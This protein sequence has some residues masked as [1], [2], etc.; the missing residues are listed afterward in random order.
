MQFSSVV[1]LLLSCCVWCPMNCSWYCVLA[2]CGLAT[3]Q[4]AKSGALRWIL[5]CLCLYLTPFLCIL[6][7]FHWVMGLSK[8]WGSISSFANG[9]GV[10]GFKNLVIPESQN[11]MIGKGDDLLNK[12]FKC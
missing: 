3:S 12:I 11:E 5:V 6:G 9:G 1:T 4:L 8:T 10:E 7:I 2:P